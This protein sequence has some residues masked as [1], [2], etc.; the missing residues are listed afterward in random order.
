MKCTSV[1]KALLKK[2]NKA[3]KPGRA[4][5]RC[6]AWRY[7]IEIFMRNSPVIADDLTRFCPKMSYLEYKL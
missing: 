1:S 7:P 5:A 2:T 3:L 6:L 4:N